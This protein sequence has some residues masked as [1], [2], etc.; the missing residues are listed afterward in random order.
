MK[1]IYKI[2][3]SAVVAFTVCATSCT[4]ELNQKPEYT[5]DGDASFN[6]IEDY[7]F[8]LTGTYSQLL[9][10]SYYGSTSGSNAFVCLPDIMSDN[11][12]EGGESLGNYSALARWTY[13]ADDAFIEDTWLDAYRI[14]RQANLTLRN[15]D[16]L[17]ATNPLAVNRIK[18]Q[19]L[20]LRA[21]VHFDL[22]KYF[23]ADAD[24]NSTKLGIPYVEKFDIEQKP[25]RLSVKATYDKIEQDLKTA[26]G[27][28]GNMDAAIQSISSTANTARSLVDSVVVNAILARMYNYAGVNDSAFKYAS[29][30]IATRPLAD[31]TNF[32]N[33]W[34]DLNTNE[35]I[36]SVKFQAFNSDIGG[37]V[38][39]SIGNRASYR[40]TTN[41]RNL[42][43]Q[44]NDIRY[45][46][47]FKAIPRRGVAR[48][49]L[50]KYQTKQ[51]ATK[52]DGIVDFKAF[53]TGEM[54]LIAA[55]ALARQ[56]NS[57][58]AL[59]LLNTLRGTRIASY[60]PGTE[61]GAALVDAIM[62]ERRKELVCEGH[63]FFDLK[64]TTRN[65]ERLTQCTDFCTL[66]PD[67]REW[68]WPIPQSEILAN[69]AMA[70]NAGY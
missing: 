47:Y 20:A 25:A 63:R 38:Y 66:A 57:S 41:L 12:F 16:N 53:R 15:I 3:L 55:E 40:P 42:Y 27:L 52:P 46:A 1:V 17:S 7:Q 10:N 18:A 49:V 59:S 8:A 44:T 21:L 30:C 61:S 69:S 51:S 33:I 56:G 34:L 13:V 37:N 6:K 5:L 14:V 31:R 4:K 54:V 2:Y 29:L 58:D 64:R 45:N 48:T 70:Q 60:V 24:R 39:Y 67:A 23:G 11:L 35:V 68:A 22:L 36:W 9:Q 32:P 26:K 19:A 28:M 65:F 43:D 50:S 62:L